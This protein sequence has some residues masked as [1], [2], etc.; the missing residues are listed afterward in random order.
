M[1]HDYTKKA[2]SLHRELKGKIDIVQKVYVNK[3]TLPLLYTPGVGAIAEY[4]AEHK[5]AV[6]EYTWRKK[7]VAVISDGSAVLGLGNIGPE[8]ALPVMEGKALLFKEYGGL[9][10]L[11]IVLNTQDEN[12]IVRTVEIL[13]PSFGAINLEDISAPKCF[14]IEK[15]LQKSLS[16]P[17]FHDDQHGTAV[18]VLAGLINAHKVV[19]KNIKHSR[20]ALIGAGA[21]GHAIAELLLY[22]GVGDLILVDRK[23]ILHT[24]RD[25]LDTYKKALAEKT[26]KEKRKGGVLE[27]VAGSD[28]IIGVS[29]RGSILPEHIRVM[30]QKSIVFA[31]ANPIPEIYPDEAK[32]AGAFVI[33]TGRSDFPNQINNVLAFPGIFKGCYE[34]SIKNITQKHLMYSALALSRLVE[35]PTK[36]K[37]IPSVTDRKVAKAVS[38]VFGN[39]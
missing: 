32:R 18:V 3:D 9:S 14:S 10:A 20:I 33:A 4:I 25:D 7:T 24:E 6:D 38:E 2:F 22:F 12:E 34:Y 39:V 37:I 13:A 21:A 23:G 8:A 17:V 35:N 15:R 27:A 28:C 36:E 30:A 19:K 5:E 26:N 1:L 31:L 16:I 29:G 11:P